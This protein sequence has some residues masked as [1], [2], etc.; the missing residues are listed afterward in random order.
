MNP[1]NS[2]SKHHGD[3]QQWHEINGFLREWPEANDFLR[4]WLRKRGTKQEREVTAT[5]T[6]RLPSCITHIWGAYDDDTT[7]DSLI[8]LI[9]ETTVRCIT[10]PDY[11]AIMKANSQR[12]E[13]TAQDRDDRDDHAR[14][15][16]ASNRAAN[17]A[18]D[19]DDHCSRAR[20]NHTSK[21]AATSTQG[22]R[23][24]VKGNGTSKHA[25][26]KTI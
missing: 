10:Y 4:E 25:P 17:P 15:N 20:G 21:R 14:G 1:S 26:T 24:H 3:S 6:T 19:H 22:P 11:A 23:K 9:K 18:Q 2:I 7:R 12:T 16:H 8:Q 5:R 13:G